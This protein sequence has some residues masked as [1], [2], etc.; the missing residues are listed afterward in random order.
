MFLWN[1]VDIV[2][3]YGHNLSPIGLI[4]LNKLSMREKPM[5]ARDSVKDDH[6]TKRDL[7]TL[8]TESIQPNLNLKGRDE[9]EQLTREL[10]SQRDEIREDKVS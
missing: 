6:R 2:T 8:Q 1:T 4:H 3:L 10:S 7:T 9:V 5:L